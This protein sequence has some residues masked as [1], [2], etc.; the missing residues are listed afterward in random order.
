MK[1]SREIRITFPNLS[2]SI[3]ETL[4]FSADSWYNTT[5]KEKKQKQEDW[6]DGR[7]IAPMTGEELPSYRRAAFANRENKRSRKE[8]TTVELSKKERRA[9]TRALFAVMLPRL[10][11]VLAAFTVMFLLMYL[12]LS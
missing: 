1:I 12:W 7:T 9:M 11:I 8:K 6:D 4:A 2:F 3:A 5:M 10:L